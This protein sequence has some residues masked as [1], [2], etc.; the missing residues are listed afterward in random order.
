MVSEQEN[1]IEEIRMI[2]S[3][4]QGHLAQRQG[5]QMEV[6]EI[7]NALSELRNYKD[8]AYKVVSGIMIKSK[9]EDLVKDLNE[10]KK[11]IEDKISAIE[12]QE[13][14]LSKRGEELQGEIA[15]KK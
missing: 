1:N 15:G 14:I 13:A 5:L 11:L 4:L 8:E 7:E 6:N 9:A 12:K 2:E 10:K 3:N